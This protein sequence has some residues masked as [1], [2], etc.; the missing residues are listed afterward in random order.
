MIDIGIP[1]SS[2]ARILAGSALLEHLHRR[3]LS[4]DQVLG[5][6]RSESKASESRGSQLSKIPPH[7]A[8]SDTRSTCRSIWDLK[9]GICH[10]M[11]SGG[12]GGNRHCSLERDSWG[13]K[14]CLSILHWRCSGFKFFS[15]FSLMILSFVDIWHFW[16]SF[17]PLPASGEFVDWAVLD[18]SPV[19]LWDL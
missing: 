2:P 12:L 16:V 17:P 10:Q 11:W 3:V 13:Q 5:S 7:I 8:T 1:L 18:L 4:L 14:K 19:D 15:F 6:L 9:A